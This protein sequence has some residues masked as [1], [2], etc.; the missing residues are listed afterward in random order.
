MCSALLPRQPGKTPAIDGA[1]PMMII[2]VTLEA[3][4]DVVDID[5]AVFDKFSSCVKRADAAAADKD[6]WRTMDL[7]ITDH[8]AE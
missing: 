2:K 6:D 8:T 1:A 4:F 7:I 5:H 3:T